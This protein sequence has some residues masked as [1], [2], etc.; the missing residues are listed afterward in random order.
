M[1]DLPEEIMR[2][3]LAVQTA[4]AV[5]KPAAYEAKAEIIARALMAER[6]RAA[7]IASPS[8]PRPC[9]CERC[10]CGNPGD[11]EAVARWDTAHAIAAAILKEPKP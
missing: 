7:R 10:Y 2:E 9:D 5:Q 8:G 6:E 11:T 1:S 3:A 4:L